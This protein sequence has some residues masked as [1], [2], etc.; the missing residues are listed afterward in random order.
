VIVAALALDRLDE[1]GGDAE[2]VRG[3]GR[4][5]LRQRPGLGGGVFVTESA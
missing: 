5:D 4:V 3:E 1:D 2:R